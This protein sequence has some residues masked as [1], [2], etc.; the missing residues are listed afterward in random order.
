MP[1]KMEFLIIWL[2][3]MKLFQL[4]FFVLFTF[5]CSGSPKNLVISESQFSPCPASPNC[6]SSQ[7]SM[8]DKEHYID[9]IIYTLEKAEAKTKLRSTLNQIPRI[10][11]VK[12]TDNYIHAECTS[13]LMRYVDDL[14]F[15]L[16][17][18][19][20]IIE[21]RSASRLGHS[22]LGV[23]RKRV[24]IIREKFKQ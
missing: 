17:G 13:L 10:K 8:D 21:V 20:K 18:S 12:E 5:Y 1:L 2:P 22:D 23:N 15:I 14:E 7:S 3:I 11:I 19:N 4:S 9:P 24:E 16:Q 6:V